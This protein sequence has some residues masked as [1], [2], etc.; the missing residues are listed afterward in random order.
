M[1]KQSLISKISGTQSSVAE[2]SSFLSCCTM[3]T[4]QQLQTF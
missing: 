1:V 4:G 3:L 2:D